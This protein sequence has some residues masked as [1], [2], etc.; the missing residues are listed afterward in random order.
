MP[1]RK[2]NSPWGAAYKEGLPTTAV[3]DQIIIDQEI[4]PAIDTGIIDRDGQWQGVVTS[5]KTFFIS[6][7]ATSIAN[8]ASVLFPNTA[9][10]DFID[11]TGFKGVEIAIKPTNAGNVQITAVMGPSS[12]SYAN[13]TPVNAATTL[14]G[15]RWNGND[16]DPM[17]NDTA[18]S[19]T[20]DVWNIFMINNTMANLKLL[21]FKITNN[22]GGASDIDFAY[23]RVV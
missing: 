13:L 3:N 15:V 16:M 5:D 6:D 14:R 1:K 7:T 19:L 11:M 8:G 18:E 9:D 21:Q 17:L 4:I 22:S 12:Q 20:A 23:L 2:A 10:R